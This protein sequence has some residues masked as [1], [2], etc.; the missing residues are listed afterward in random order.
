M[1]TAQIASNNTMTVDSKYLMNVG[2]ISV[3]QIFYPDL[4]THYEKTRKALVH[5][6]SYPT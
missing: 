2:K 5:N 3:M 1:K 6:M 4:L